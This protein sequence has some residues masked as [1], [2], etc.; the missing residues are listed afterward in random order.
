MAMQNAGAATHLRHV[1][2]VDQGCSE[3]RGRALPDGVPSPARAI[4]FERN[5]ITVRDGKG[6]KD[7]R[8]MLPGL[9]KWPFQQHLG[10]VK[11]IHQRDGWGRVQIPDAL[12]RK[13]PN[14]PTDWRWQ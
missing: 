6:A 9:L 13:Y 7:R 11:A 1:S 12:D 3:V 2:G 10:R 4:D 14:A 8:T 5:E